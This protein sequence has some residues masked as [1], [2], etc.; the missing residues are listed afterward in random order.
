MRSGEKNAVLNGTLPANGVIY[1]RVYGNQ[2]RENIKLF[3]NDNEFSTTQNIPI[4]VYRKPPR[5][6]REVK[7]QFTKTNPNYKTNPKF[8]IILIVCCKKQKKFDLIP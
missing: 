3:D 5:L 4:F 8:N 2:G 6:P 7:L 1:E